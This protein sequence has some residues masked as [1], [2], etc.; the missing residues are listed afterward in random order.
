MRLGALV[1]RQADKAVIDDG[2]GKLELITLGTPLTDNIG[3]VSVKQPV[4]M[5]H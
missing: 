4:K 3:T 1:Q 5:D 2:V